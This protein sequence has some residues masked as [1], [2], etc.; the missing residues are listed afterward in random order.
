MEARKKAKAMRSTDGPGGAAHQLRCAD[1]GVETRGL[2]TPHLAASRA[3][4]V[5][6][7]VPLTISPPPPRPELPF[8]SFFGPFGIDPQSFE[9]KKQRS[10]FKAWAIDVAAFGPGFTLR[11]W[12][13]REC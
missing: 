12:E 7:K 6:L 11:D 13:S 4:V 10:F 3:D 8:Q 9:E 5:L 1:P 2:P